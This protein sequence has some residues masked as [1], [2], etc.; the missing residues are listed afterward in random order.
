MQSGGKALEDY[1]FRKATISLDELLARSPK[2]AHRKR[3][4]NDIES[5]GVEDVQINDLLV[6]KP[7]DLIPVDGIIFSDNAQIDEST[8]TGEPL[9][10]TKCKGD[11]V[12]SGTVNTGNVFE[13]MIV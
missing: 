4:E 2:I 5:I 12:Y 10:K 6:I 8:L 1:A 9:F 3:N 11:E 13:S 7:G